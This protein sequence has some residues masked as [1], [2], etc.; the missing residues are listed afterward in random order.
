MAFLGLLGTA[1]LGPL[2]GGALGGNTG[3]MAT[4]AALNTYQGEENALE[5]Q[6]LTAETQTSIRAH[7]FAQTMEVADENAKESN[8]MQGYV[9]SLEDADKQQIEKLTNQISSQGQA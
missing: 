4:D 5:I 8:L 9:I 6:Q 1:L 2:L 7:H 3:T